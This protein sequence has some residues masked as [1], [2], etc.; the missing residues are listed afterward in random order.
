VELSS[1]DYT[2]GSGN[3]TFTSTPTNSTTVLFQQ[4][5]ARIGAA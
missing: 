3:Y 2:E 5:F 4:T 1:G